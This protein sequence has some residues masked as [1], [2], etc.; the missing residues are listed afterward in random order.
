MAQLVLWCTPGFNSGDDSIDGAMRAAADFRCGFG[1]RWRMRLLRYFHREPQNAPMD[2]SAQTVV[3]QYMNRM[4]AISRDPRSY[5]GRFAVFLRAT[6]CAAVLEAERK[7]AAKQ[8]LALAVVPGPSADFVREMAPDG[9]TFDLGR[10]DGESCRRERTAKAD[11]SCGG[12]RLN[13][14]SSSGWPDWELPAV[15]YAL[16]DGKRP[17]EGE[18]DLTAERYRPPVIHGA[19]REERDTSA[20][21]LALAFAEEWL[22]DVTLNRERLAEPLDMAA[23]RPT[24]AAQAISCLEGYRGPTLLLSDALD[25]FNGR[26]PWRPAYGVVLRAAGVEPPGP[27]VLEPPDSR[28]A[29][30]AAPDCG[31]EFVQLLAETHCYYHLSD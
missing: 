27:T 3:G 12:H 8:G 17:E 11:G 13:C 25:A 10:C 4:M 21:A 5:G 22:A 16:G 23:D 18:E 15:I 30:C 24:L 28:L 7:Y 14:W 31:R 29:I 6:P 20:N 19:T 1:S 2:L 26:H 9:M